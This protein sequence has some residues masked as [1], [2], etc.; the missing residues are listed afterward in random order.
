MGNVAR[1][2]AI[3]VV[4]PVRNEERLLRSALEALERSVE[5][6]ERSGAGVHVV[7][8]LDSCSDASSGI[9]RAWQ[10]RVRRRSAFGVTVVDFDGENVG[11]ARALGCDVLLDVFRDIDL[12]RVWLATTDADSRVPLH[13]LREQVAKHDRG[14]D[15]WAGR[16][17]VT[18]WPRHRL[19]VAAKWQRDYDAE[20][21]PIHGASLGVNAHMYLAAGGFP[22]LRTSEDRGLHDALLA[23]GA[24]IHYDSST[25]VIT[26]ARRDAR[27]PGGFAA[28]LT[29]VELPWRTA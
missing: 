7:V 5:Y 21:R 13:W 17:A 6:V 22:P 29:R 8:V 16:V 20:D 3:G 28:A 19:A 4:I 10:E 2:L 18:E 11:R 1:T 15:V 26:S 9:A 27:A 14:V 12:A 25:R 24:N 23:R